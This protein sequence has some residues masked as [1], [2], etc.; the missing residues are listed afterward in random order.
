MKWKITQKIDRILW[1]AYRVA[2]GLRAVRNK[3]VVIRHIMGGDRREEYEYELKHGLRLTVN[4]TRMDRTAIFSVQEIFNEEVYHFPECKDSRVVVDLGANIGTYVLYAS[5]K[6][7]GARIYAIEPDIE[8]VRQLRHNISANDLN[9][10]VFVVSAA[11]S[12]TEG[13]VKL[14]RNT[15]SSRGHSLAPIRDSECPINVQSMSLERMFDTCKIEV[16]DLLKMDIEGTEYQV[17]FSCNESTLRR[18]R[19]MAI[20]YHPLSLSNPGIL[21]DRSRYSYEGLCKFLQENGYR[22]VKGRH[23]ILFAIRDSQ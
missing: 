7:P 18:I 13:E 20:E 3:A 23:E 15:E 10:R 6:Y 21:S 12:A 22:T 1:Q 8:N 9:A 19:T 11:I 16:C 14:Y 2:D 5:W 4:N 17:L